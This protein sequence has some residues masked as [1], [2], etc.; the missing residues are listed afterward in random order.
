MQFDGAG[1]ASVIRLVKDGDVTTRIIRKGD[2]DLVMVV[3]GMSIPSVLER[4]L[5]TSDFGGPVAWVSSYRNPAKTGGTVV[6]VHLNEAVT[7]R[8]VEK[9]GAIEWRFGTSNGP[10]RVAKSGPRATPPTTPA[11]V[12]FHPQGVGAGTSPAGAPAAGI[13]PSVS[14]SPFAV[15]NPRPGKKKKKYTGRRINLAIKDANIQHVLAFLARVGGVN[16]VTNDKVSGTVSF[17]LED[18]PW[19]LALDMILKISGMDYVKEEGIYRVAPVADIQKEYELEVEKKKKITELKQLQVKL[20]PVN[21]AEAKQMVKQ[22]QSILSAKGQVSVDERTNTLIVKDIEEHV[23][24][25][26]DLVRRLDAQT[27]Q[28]LIEARIVEASSDFSKQVG[29]Q[30]GGNALASPA[31]G[32]ETGLIFPS[33]IGLAGGA[34]GA[35]SNTSGLYST[36]SPNFAVNLPAAAGQGAGGAIGLTLGSIGQAANIYLRLSAAEEEGV[37]KIVSAPRITTVDNMKASIKQG[38]SFPVSVVSAQGVNTQFFKAELSLNVTPHVTQDGN[39]QL[40]IDITKNEPDFSQVGANGN[41]T[42]RTKEANTEL[43][44][45]DG[46]TTVIGGIFTRSTTKN[47]KRIPFFADLPLLGWFFRNSNETERRSE[48]LIFITPRIVNRQASKVKLTSD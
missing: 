9:D 42:I 2:R 46:D 13:A 16:I 34:S 32:N 27:P 40:Q 12:G 21:Y 25:V 29:V 30:W 5:D 23:L 20:I 43:L 36:D 28:V 8:L 18:V 26:D 19:D 15:L 10:A 11:G 38:V 44:L 24:A 7:H 1:G 33:T 22:V 14:D 17:Y 4:T 41:P 45:K 31:T 48:M 37:V 39:I 35:Q 6:S 3:D 47:Y